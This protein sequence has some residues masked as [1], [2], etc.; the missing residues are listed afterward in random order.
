MK[1]VHLSRYLKPYFSLAVIGTILLFAQAN[2]E[3][4]LPDYLSKIVNVGIQQEGI[5]NSVPEAIRESQMKKVFLFMSAENKTKVL[6]AYS[7]ENSST[8]DD[9]MLNRYPL[10]SNDSIF[11]LKDQSK[12]TINLLNLAM[13]KALLIVFNI[14]N[15]IANASSPQ[16][17][18]N[19]SIFANIS[20]DM[21]YP[22]LESLPEQNRTLMLVQI[23]NYLGKFPES[24]LIQG[25]VAPIKAEYVI[26]GM[27]VAQIQ[28]IYILKVGGLMLI[29]T[30]LSVL[31]FGGWTS[32][33]CLGSRML[34]R[35]FHCALMHQRDSINF[36]QHPN[37]PIY[38]RY[39]ID[40]NADNINLPNECFCTDDGIRCQFVRLTK[41]SMAWLIALAV[42]IL[43]C[44]II[45]YFQS[46]I[47]NSRC[48][49]TD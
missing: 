13:A 42:I 25:A 40:S 11:I 12:D 34:E 33:D 6:S 17:S 22:L 29:L 21:I 4:A 10:L 38:Q 37:H 45:L 16:L 2:T 35:P 8:A 36:Q 48:S 14:D 31:V 27:D 49:E 7:L 26:I 15:Y 19:M 39:N 43:I 32:Q 24:Y 3:L 20:S 47:Q 41:P 28:L 46:S 9:K 18:M 5:E 1:K 23:E 30:I 44:M